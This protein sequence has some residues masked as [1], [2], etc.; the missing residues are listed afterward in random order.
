[1]RERSKDLCLADPW[2]S[3]QDDASTE[4]QTGSSIGRLALRESEY[5]A[6]DLTLDGWVQDDVR[7]KAGFRHGHELGITLRSQSDDMAEIELRPFIDLGEERPRQL[8]VHCAHMDPDLELLALTNTNH[9]GDAVRSV[10]CRV[11]AFLED[12][13]SMAGADRHCAVSRC[14]LAFLVVV[15]HRWAVLIWLCLENGLERHQH[16]A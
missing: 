1:V 6:F 9:E 10:V 11:V 3:S 5:V 16:L 15:V 14:P 12:G 4:W 2:R 8:A 13:S 7:V